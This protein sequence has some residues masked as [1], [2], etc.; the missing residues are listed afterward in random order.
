LADNII[1]INSNCDYC[2][3]K[4]GRRCVKYINNN[5]ANINSDVV[6]EQESDKCYYKT[7]CLSCYKKIHNLD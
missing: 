7:A 5:L 4:S 2:E 1:K 3:S 6:L